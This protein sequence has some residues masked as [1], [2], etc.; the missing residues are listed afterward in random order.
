LADD[1]L[2][3][4][5]SSPLEPARGRGTGHD[6]PKAPRPSRASGGWGPWLAG[7]ILVGALAVL[8]GYLVVGGG[9]DDT[10]TTT[11]E[12]ATTTTAVISE[13]VGVLPDGYTPVGDRLGMKVE[14][15]LL[16]P[17]AV[18][19]SLSTV[20]PN[21]LAPEETSGYQ[22]GVWALILV[23]GRR[24]ENVRESTDALAPGFVSVEFPAGGYGAADVVSIE[25]RGVAERQLEEIGAETVEP[26]TLRDD[27]VFVTAALSPARFTLDAGV[28]LV[29]SDLT[30]SPTQGGMAWTLEGTD[31]KA[32]AFVYPNLL[33]DKGE[34]GTEASEPRVENANFGFPFSQALGSTPPRREGRLLFDPVEPLTFST[35]VAFTG[36]FSFQVSWTVYEPTT[37]TIPFGEDVAVTEVG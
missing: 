36:R 37:T 8:G 13:P 23:D 9:G 27:G 21:T 4:L 14:R 11:T 1:P 35:G 15:I 17:D 32:G 30:I 31:E 33:L 5:L 7:S 34:A 28:E 2:R 3:E 10:A 29:F 20:V 6:Q 22:G 16:R 26:F 19:V 18:F 12:A 25:L 24:I